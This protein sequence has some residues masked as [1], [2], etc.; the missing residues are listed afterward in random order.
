M[1]MMISKEI[2]NGGLECLAATAVETKSEPD[3]LVEKL[4]KRHDIGENCE[5]ETRGETR[6]DNNCDNYFSNLYI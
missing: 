5:C 3:D 1:T 6:E 2:Q 4:K